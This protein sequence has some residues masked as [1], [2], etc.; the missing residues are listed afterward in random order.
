MLQ[1]E[2]RSIDD[3]WRRAHFQLISAVLYQADP[4][5]RIGK[6]IGEEYDN[7]ARRIIKALNCNSTMREVEKLVFEAFLQEHGNAAGL[8]ADYRQISMEV[9]RLLKKFGS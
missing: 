8:P 1:T 9:F 6:N 5:R 2:R 3:I 7:E 4:L